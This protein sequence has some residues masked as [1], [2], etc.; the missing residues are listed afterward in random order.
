MRQP[1]GQ[2]VNSLAI[3]L[4]GVA[5]F[6]P[7]ITPRLGNLFINFLIVGAFLGFF[8]PERSWR[9]GLWLAIPVVT[10]GLVSLADGPGI[11][12][13]INTAILGGQALAAGAITGA[14]GARFSPRRLPYADLR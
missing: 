4:G 8:W 13:I 14:L 1:A 11:G 10:L 2:L 9:W 7:S 3:L 5:L 12:Q 6:A